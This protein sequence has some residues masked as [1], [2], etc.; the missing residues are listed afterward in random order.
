MT[1]RWGQPAAGVLVVLAMAALWLPW[2]TA[3]GTTYRFDGRRLVD[4]GV[5]RWRGTEVIGQDATVLTAVAALVVLAVLIAR[6]RDGVSETAA[7]WVLGA[8]GVVAVTLAV[9]GIVGWGPSVGALGTLAC[10]LLTVAGA[11]AG[12]VPRRTGFA[13]LVPAAVVLLA[14]PVWFGP[15]GT[16]RDAPPTAGAALEKVVDITSIQEK[17]LSRS[18]DRQLRLTPGER[19]LV[20]VN[21]GVGLAL[22]AGLV[23]VDDTGRPVTRVLTTKGRVLGVVDDRVVLWWERAE[24]VWVFSPDSPDRPAV[25]ANVG[26]GVRLLSSGILLSGVTVDRLD[27]TRLDPGQRRDLSRRVDPNDAPPPSFAAPQSSSRSATHPETGEAAWVDSAGVVGDRVLVNGRDVAGGRDPACGLTATAGDA[28]LRELTGIAPARGGGWWLTDGGQLLRLDGDGTLRAGPRAGLDGTVAMLTDDAGSLHLATRSGLFRLRDP[29]AALRTLPPSPPDCAAH[30]TVAG[31]VAVAP[32]LPIFGTPIGADGARAYVS[33]TGQITAIAGDGT[34]RVV[35]QLA[36][37]GPAQV[38]P[39]GG[40]GFWWLERIPAG[41]AITDE[42]APGALDHDTVRLVHATA[43]GAVEPQPRT[44]AK[45]VTRLHP[46]L[47]GGPPLGGRCLR[48]TAGEAVPPPVFTQLGCGVTLVAPDGQGW[49][50]GDDDQLYS[51]NAGDTAATKRI[52]PNRVTDTGVAVQLAHGVLPGELSLH[53]PSLG[54][55][56]TGRLLVLSEDVLLAVSPTEVTVLAQ[57]E[58]LRSAQLQPVAGGTVVEFGSGAFRL[59]Y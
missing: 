9:A 24:Q 18:G 12:L 51:R 40:G 53:E 13:R 41:T 27:V 59:D 33:E 25:V 57:D 35:G 58:R 48:L 43:A 11:L 3:G 31:P 52:V 44:T 15:A 5:E 7:W 23:A 17:S 21:G 29:D 10:G 22:P 16:A 55:D 6:L 39:D 38:A 46:D 42:T 32:L 45:S 2:W 4:L 37:P 47:A 19:D 34:P 56:S 49:A 20:P 36:G 1:A 30:P 54:V 26:D 8:A 14:V 28:F 50:V